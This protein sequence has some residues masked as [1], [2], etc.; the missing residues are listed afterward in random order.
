MTKFCVTYNGRLQSIAEKGANEARVRFTGAVGTEAGNVG[1][2]YEI[3]S[4]VKRRV[5]PYWLA[6]RIADG[7]GENVGVWAVQ[8]SSTCSL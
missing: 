7:V 6:A 8:D 5:H 3:H 2:R 1:T 4:P